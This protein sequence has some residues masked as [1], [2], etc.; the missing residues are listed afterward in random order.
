MTYYSFH[1]WPPSLTR[2][3]TAF[4]APSA[5]HGAALALRHF[6]ALGCD[7]G[8]PG[9]HVDFTD[10]DGNVHTLLVDEVL[11]WLKEPQQAGFVEREHLAPLVK[12]GA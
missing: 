6:L 11:D 9:G 7:L 5:H 2:P 1:W 12:S 8:A 10:D 3:H 4:A